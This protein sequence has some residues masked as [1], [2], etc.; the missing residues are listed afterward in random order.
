MGNK[1]DDQIATEVYRKVMDEL[2]R[3][4]P[5]SITNNDED[6]PRA[7][8]PNE[9]AIVREGAAQIAVG[10]TKWALA[11]SRRVTSAQEDGQRAITSAEQL[12]LKKA[13]TAALPETSNL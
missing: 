6:A 10:V 5:R 4:L 13:I 7:L 1:T 3:Q 2:Q 12:D 8:T 9:M 11:L